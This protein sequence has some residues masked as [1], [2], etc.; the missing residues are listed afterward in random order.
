MAQDINNTLLKLLTYHIKCLR[1][2][3][4]CLPLSPFHLDPP[5]LHEGQ[6]F[7]W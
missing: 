6:G 2:I 7:P 3:N 1:F 4:P 5:A